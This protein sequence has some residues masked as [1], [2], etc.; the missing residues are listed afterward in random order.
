MLLARTCPSW[1]P[2]R[3]SFSL[4]SSRSLTREN[5]TSVADSSS[6]SSVIGSRFCLGVVGNPSEMAPSGVESPSTGK[7]VVELVRAD[8]G[9][10]VVFD[11][12]GP[13]GLLLSAV[14]FSLPSGKSGTIEA[15]AVGCS[16]DD[17]GWNVEEAL[18]ALVPLGGVE[19]GTVLDP[20][21]SLGSLEVADGDAAFSGNRVAAFEGTPTALDVVEG[22]L[23]EEGR[24]EEEGCVPSGS[25]VADSGEAV[26]TVESTFGVVFKELPPTVVE[27]SPGWLGVI[28]VSDEEECSFGSAADV[29]AEPVAPMIAGCS[30]VL[31]VVDSVELE[32]GPE[33]ISESPGLLV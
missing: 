2:P 33:V 23:V 30:V 31:F 7:C 13:L 11:T 5:L 22:L 6:P 25:V 16:V 26:G 9:A 3:R 17:A 20:N 14:R 1:E 32:L 28:L 19:G 29:S 8:V 18:G 24:S 10:L 15:A 21:E 12:T 27:E 4:C